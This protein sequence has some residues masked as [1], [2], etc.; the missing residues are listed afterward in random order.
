MSCGRAL[1]Y[2]VSISIILKYFH[3]VVFIVSLYSE[4]RHMCLFMLLL[5][6]FFFL[7]T[8]VINVNVVLHMLLYC[9]CYVVVLM[10]YI[11]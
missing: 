5:S 2:C 6:C 10:R 3:V 1:L 7:I 11:N 8:Y 9:C 4:L